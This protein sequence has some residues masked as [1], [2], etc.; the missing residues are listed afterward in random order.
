VVLSASSYGNWLQCPEQ[1]RIL[2][3]GLAPHEESFALAAGSAMHIGIA[4]VYRE[5]VLQ[6]ELHAIRSTNVVDNA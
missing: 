1:Y 2:T 6:R 3:S 4:Q 5:I